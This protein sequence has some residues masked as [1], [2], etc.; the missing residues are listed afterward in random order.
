M[1]EGSVRKEDKYGYGIMRINTKKGMSLM[2]EEVTMHRTMITGQRHEVERRVKEMVERG[3]TQLTEISRISK[4][5]LLDY[6]YVRYG[7][8]LERE[9]LD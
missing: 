1:E 6:E 9:W 4:G 2:E 8:R 3:W 7:C 5:E